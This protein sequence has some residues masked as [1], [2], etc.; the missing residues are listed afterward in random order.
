[1]ASI[2]LNLVGCISK[3]L[4]TIPIQKLADTRIKTK[5]KKKEKKKDQNTKTPTVRKKR[6]LYKHQY[7]SL[8]FLKQNDFKILN[9]KCFNPLVSKYESW[10]IV[11]NAFFQI[12]R[13]KYS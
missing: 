8:K 2:T 10:K 12:P 6:F 4:V 9:F 5:Q 1:M 3:E 7:T 11:S 13:E